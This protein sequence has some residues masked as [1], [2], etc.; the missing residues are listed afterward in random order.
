MVHF[1]F[2]DKILSKNHIVLKTKHANN[3]AQDQAYK[4]ITDMNDIYR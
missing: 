3:L 1:V 4:I 2:L